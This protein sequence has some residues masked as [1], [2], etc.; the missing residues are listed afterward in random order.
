MVAPFVPSQIP[1]LFYDTPIFQGAPAS[2]VLRLVNGVSIAPLAFHL[3][4]RFPQRQPVGR[5]LIA[6]AYMLCL[7]L[8]AV[9]LFAT[10]KWLRILSG[11]LLLLSTVGL[12]LAAG[13][14][15]LR[16]SR[17]IDPANPRAAQQA[18]LLFLSISLAGLPALLRPIGLVFRVELL[19][20]SVMLAALALIPLGVAYA[21]LRTDLFGVDRFLRRGLAYA[22]LSVLVLAGY[23]GLTVALTA[24]LAGLAPSL[25]GLA[26]L[27]G[28]L[29]AAL[30]FEPARRRVQN[31]IDR[32]LYPDRINFQRAIAEARHRLESAASR[33]NI[34]H[35]LTHDLPPDLG[36]EWAALSLSPAPETP[37]EN[38]TPPAWNARLVVAGIPLGRYWL[39]PRRFGPSYDPDELALLNGLAAQAALALAYADTIFELRQLNRELEQRV[40]QRTAQ[41]VDAQRILAAYEERQRLARELHDSVTQALFSINLSARALKNLVPRDPQATAAGLSELETAAQQ[42]LG[43]MRALLAQLRAA[44]QASIPTFPMDHLDIHASLPHHSPAPLVPDQVIV[45][46]S[47][48]YSDPPADDAYTPVIRQFPAEIPSTDLVKILSEHCERLRREPGPDGLQPALDVRLTLPAELLLPAPLAHEVLQIAREALHNVLKHSGARQASLSVQVKPGAGHITGAVT[49]L[50]LLELRDCGRGFDPSLPTSGFGLRGM[51]E[52]VFAL[53]GQVKIESQPG[54]GARL[55]L[56]LPVASQ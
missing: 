23:F 47:L 55:R 53:G 48:P 46:Y 20:Y 11:V 4:A 39:G 45:D 3:A 40:S 25:R 50:L 30:L 54:S 6:A 15:L 21:I 42:A 8:L 10:L 13:G 9:L 43:E 33:E 36:A 28:I 37:G 51:R 31:W 34:L 27:A 41:A 38:L 29:V 2:L 14:L 17:R 35:L 32:W 12:I 52:R 18:R 22:V 7:G 24:V 1:R 19:P 49:P 44:P 56:T 16:Q 26:A 5:A